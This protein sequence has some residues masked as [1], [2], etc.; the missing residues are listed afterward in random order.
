MKNNMKIREDGRASYSPLRTCVGC[1]EIFPQQSLVRFNLIEGHAVV[2][3]AGTKSFGRSVYICPSE[4]C[5]ALARKSGRLVFK[6]AKNDLIA[7]HLSE[8]EWYIL[9]NKFNSIIKETVE[10][11]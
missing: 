6:R 3:K 2:L 8:T 5:F 11:R 1:R 10:R 4:K 9:K 7:A